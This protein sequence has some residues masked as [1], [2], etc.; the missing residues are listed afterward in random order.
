MLV[1]EIGAGPEPKAPTM[2]PDATIET[3]DADS[4]YNPT[5]LADAQEI[6][7][8]LFG[9][10]DAVLAS[11][12]L[13]H[14]PYFRTHDVLEQWVKLLKPEGY[15]H[16]IV[17]SLEWAAEQILSGRPHIA[18][19]GHLYGGQTTQWDVHLNGF[20]MKRLRAEME[21]V[22]LMVDAAASTPYPIR[23]MNGEVVKA[24]QHYCRG[25]LK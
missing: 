25:R 18:I 21:W 13:E 8:K 7:E 24:Q 17:P 22:G 15:L 6:P 20:T 19:F 5:Y 11:H 3:L 4:Q 23:A 1:L 16:I 14:V 2:W 9:K 10:Y 12:V